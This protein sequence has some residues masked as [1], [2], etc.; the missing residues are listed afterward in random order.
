M[1]DSSKRGV[2]PHRIRLPFWQRAIGTL[3]CVVLYRLLAS[4]PLPFVNRE[5]VAAVLSSRPFGLLDM[6]AGGTMSRI[7]VAALGVS[8][9]VSASI[10]IQLMGVVLPVVSLLQR[11]GPVGQKKIRGATL[12]LSGGLSVVSGTMMALSYRSAGIL[13]AGFLMGV[14]IP[15][16][17][18][19]ACSVGLAALGCYIDEKLFGKGVSVLIGA[20]V[21]ASMPGR[22]TEA[23]TAAYVRW[24]GIGTALLAVG[25]IAFFLLVYVLVNC[26]LELR[27]SYSAKPSGGAGDLDS[28][29]VLP[30][31]ALPGGVLPVIFASYFLS[32][33]SMFYGVAGSVPGF[34]LA[35]DMSSWFDPAKPWLSLGAAF[36]A[37]MVWTFGRLSQAMSVNGAE[38]AENLRRGGCTVHGVPPGPETEAFLSDR[39]RRMT[40]LGSLGL[41]IVALVPAALSAMLGIPSIGYAGTS[42]LLVVAVAQEAVSEASAELT[43]DRYMAC[44]P[45]IL[46]GP[47]GGNAY[48]LLEKAGR[49]GR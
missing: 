43:S 9:Y 8:P 19:A 40:D 41:C 47:R 30:V 46:K 38:V 15:V 20:G 48:A 22:I 13:P 33:P 28:I 29:S 44:M 39:I 36:Y 3:A 35:L 14:V 42:V 7:S 27:L 6:L 24:G 45:R 49:D 1:A 2:V 32:L 5:A 12:A 11:S 25:S 16:A 17:C 37:L 31:V 10:V 21:L 26:R 34:I 18:M 23:G 4:L